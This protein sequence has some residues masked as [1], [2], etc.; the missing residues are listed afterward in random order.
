[1]VRIGYLYTG[2][3]TPK[4]LWENILAK[5]QQFRRM[6]DSRRSLADYYAKDRHAPDKTYGCE[7]P[8]IDGCS[9]DWARE[10][11]RE[12]QLLSKV[13]DTANGVRFNTHLRL[14]R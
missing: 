13:V 3:R 10:R 12:A 7:A 2:A 5:R 6:P 14:H 1:M 4:G 11:F 9:F 8:L